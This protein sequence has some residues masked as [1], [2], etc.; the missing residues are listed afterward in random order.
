MAKKYKGRQY[1][2]AFLE[3]RGDNVWFLFVK[4]R[5]KYKGQTNQREEFAQTIT[6]PNMMRAKIKANRLLLLKYN[7][8]LGSLDFRD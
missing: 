8:P 5:Q 6:A 1:T 4:W 7:L 2:K 3:D